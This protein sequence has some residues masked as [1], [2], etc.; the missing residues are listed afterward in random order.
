MSGMMT[1]GI[2]EHRSAV[3]AQADPR[4][5]HFLGK[6]GRIERQ[7]WIR[8]CVRQTRSSARNSRAGSDGESNSITQASSVP[9]LG[10]MT[11]T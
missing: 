3:T 8:P 5:D 4:A 7:A 2:E 6:V 1:G 9:R 11:F 10:G